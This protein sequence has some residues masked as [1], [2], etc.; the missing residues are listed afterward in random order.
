M[1]YKNADLT[2]L[3]GGLT[4]RASYRYLLICKNI[5]KSQENM[6]YSY[7]SGV[8]AYTYHTNVLKFKGYSLISL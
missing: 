7:N 3:H 8:P 4:S 2:Q 5:L 6:S 1:Y